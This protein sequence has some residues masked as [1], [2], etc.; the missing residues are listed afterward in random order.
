M[1]YPAPSFIPMS[2]SLGSASPMNNS[3]SI[4]AEHVYVCIYVWCMMYVYLSVSRC[5]HAL[6]TPNVNDDHA[7]SSQ[8]SVMA[9]SSYVRVRR[10]EQ[11]TL[12]R[13]K[14]WRQDFPSLITVRGNWS[15]NAVY[16]NWISVNSLTVQL[17]SSSS[18]FNRLDI[19]IYQHFHDPHETD[20]WDE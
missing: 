19:S 11:K 14:D 7:L 9:M 13:L 5:A 8:Y 12:R 10:K 4:I 18:S 15:H 16:S 20:G 2:M 1:G 6:T 17:L 3:K